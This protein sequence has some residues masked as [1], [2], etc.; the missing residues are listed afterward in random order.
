MIGTLNDGWLLIKR[1]WVQA[2]GLQ[3]L[4]PALVG[5]VP[6]CQLIKQAERMM[7]KI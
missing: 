3:T 7:F 1:S 6:G 4:T 2:Q 5:F